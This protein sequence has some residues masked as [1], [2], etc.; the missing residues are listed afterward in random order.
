MGRIVAIDYGKKRVG[1][2]AT[3]ILKIIAGPVGT[4]DSREIITFLKDYMKREEV[5]LIVVGEPRQMNNQASESSRF[6]EPF[7]RRLKKEF[8]GT[9]VDRMDERFTSRIA[10]QAMIDA[11]LKK[12]ARQR[13]ELVD[14]TSA[15]IILQSYLEYSKN[16]KD[17]NSR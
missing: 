5:E 13:K 3:D 11:G 1:L 9:P 10:F 8:P 17:L 4:V 14:S 12:K 7:V 2:A 6:V 16:K 15:V